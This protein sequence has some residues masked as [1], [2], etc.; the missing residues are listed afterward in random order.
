MSN[1]I[2][3]VYLCRDGDNEELRYSIRSVKHFYPDATIWVAGGRPR[4]YVG[5]YLRVSKFGNSYSTQRKILRS[6]FLSDRIP[7]DIV[8][9]NDDFFFVDKVDDFGYYCSGKLGNRIKQ[10][11]AN[12]F[13]TTYVEELHDL[14]SHCLKN[15]GSEMDFELHVPMLVKKSQL[16]DIFEDDVMWRSNYGNKYIDDYNIKIIKDV[17]FYNQNKY[18]FKE[19]SFLSRRYPFI[20]TLDSSFPVVKDKLLSK[21]FPNP[22]EHERE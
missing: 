2:T 8:I 11:T 12:G 10:Y 18:A 5:N 13:S 16:A 14:R 6:I 7:E 4:W 3:F 20:S 19:H 21:K 15:Y 9:M 1:N 17:K 22:T